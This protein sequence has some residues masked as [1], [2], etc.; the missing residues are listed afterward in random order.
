MRKHFLRCN[1]QPV[2]LPE[3]I[4]RGCSLSFSHKTCVCVCVRACVANR[5][6]IV[7][8]TNGYNWLLKGVQHR[9]ADWS[10]HTGFV[11]L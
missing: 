11:P 4:M 9:P 7:C 8:G 5:N 1:E 2:K 10:Q 3:E 6:G